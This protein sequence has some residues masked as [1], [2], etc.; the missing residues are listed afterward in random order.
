MFS[1]VQDVPRP[2][3]PVV[4]RSAPRVTPPK[5]EALPAKGNAKMLL[6]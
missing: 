1:K 5:G 4:Q 2:E 6:A 3:E